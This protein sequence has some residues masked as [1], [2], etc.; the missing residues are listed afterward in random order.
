M[1]LPAK[2]SENDKMDVTGKLSEIMKLSGQL[3]DERVAKGDPRDKE[4]RGKAMAIAWDRAKRGEVENP[5]A[6]Y[7]YNNPFLTA[8][9]RYIIGAGNVFLTAGV[10]EGSQYLMGG[11]VGRVATAG[12]IALTHYL[13]PQELKKTVLV[14]GV[15]GFLLHELKDLVVDFIRK[16]QKT[17]VQQPGAVAQNPDYA[18][19]LQQIPY[20]T[21]DYQFMVTGQ[22]VLFRA[23][24][25][26]REFRVDNPQVWADIEKI[27][28]Q[29][30][31]DLGTVQVVVLGQALY[32]TVSKFEDMEKRV[33]NTGG[34]AFEWMR[35]N[36]K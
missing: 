30:M 3:Y 12:V 17:Q 7:F 33:M 24:R 25:V 28:E 11:M 23:T 26:V 32:D 5:S 15:T 16:Q 19:L 35:P 2:I 14:T 13:A 21:G 9:N 29:A 34:N 22:T 10:K 27:L 36:S 1:A 8:Q 4:T 18:T 20:K 6:P 31:V